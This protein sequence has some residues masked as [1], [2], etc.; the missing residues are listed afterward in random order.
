MLGYPYF[1]THAYR[2]SVWN[3]SCDHK[4]SNLS[5]QWHMAYWGGMD[6]LNLRESSTQKFKAVWNQTSSLW[7]KKKL[8][9]SFESDLQ[10][11]T[12]IDTS[13]LVWVVELSLKRV[14]HANSFKA[15][16]HH[17]FI[18]D[19][20][21]NV[22][23]NTPSKKDL[24]GSLKRHWQQKSVG[25]SS[26]ALSAAPSTESVHRQREKW[27]RRNTKSRPKTQRVA[28]SRMNVAG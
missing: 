26:G 7:T 28:L 9:N 10:I 11:L 17:I 3:K 6:W 14:G 13:C 21:F 19:I 16:L 27:D 5:D 1:W 12:S 2:S 18:S 25:I 8:R 4:F 20:F 15:D 23:S 24:V 22:I